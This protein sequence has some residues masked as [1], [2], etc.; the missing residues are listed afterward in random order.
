MQGPDDRL[1][2]HIQQWQVR[3]FDDEG[4]LQAIEFKGQQDSQ[5]PDADP[6]EQVGRM[7]RMLG[8]LAQPSSG[9]VRLTRP[10]CTMRSLQFL[11]EALPG[12]GELNFC[13]ELGEPLTDELLGVVLGM[14]TRVQNLTCPSL[15]LQSDQHA[16]TPWPWD[17]LTCTTFDVGQV[18]R[19]P[20][21]AGTQGGRAVWVEE[22]VIG[23]EVDQVSFAVPRMGIAVHTRNAPCRGADTETHTEL[24]RRTTAKAF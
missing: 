2:A 6:A 18:C 15:A 8:L 20:D 17:E 24:A 22:L 3:V 10:L 14:G 11:A 23:P 13:I 19:L 4:I 7:L 5:P 9:L 12:L 16:N 1:M 21:P